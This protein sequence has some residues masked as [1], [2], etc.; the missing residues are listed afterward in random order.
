MTGKLLNEKRP[1]LGFVH[2][3]KTAG[4]TLKFILRN[5]TFCRHCDLQT[6]VRHGTFR[7]EDYRFMRKVT[8]SALAA[9][10]CATSSPADSTWPCT[11]R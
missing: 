4:T 8:T 11:G 2:I 10:P 3:P 5:S 1:I 6:T 9:S 7:D